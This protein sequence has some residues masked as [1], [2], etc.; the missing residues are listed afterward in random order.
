LKFPR[1]ELSFEKKSHE[2]EWRTATRSL[3][4]VTDHA[5]ECRNA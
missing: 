5:V 2:S 4:D 3:A 1:Q